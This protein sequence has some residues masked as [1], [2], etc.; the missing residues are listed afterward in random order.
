MSF[1]GGEAGPPIDVDTICSNG[2]CDVP[3]E[4][5]VNVRYDDDGGMV[6]PEAAVELRQY[7]LDYTFDDLTNVPYFAGATSVLVP[8]GEQVTLRLRVAGAVQR[9]F[10]SSRFGASEVDGAARLTIEGYDQEN[11]LVQVSGDLDLAFGDFVV[12]GGNP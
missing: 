10:F 1:D 9:D 12:T 5:E 3:A 4:L 11:A 6:D 8:V 7:R 2:G